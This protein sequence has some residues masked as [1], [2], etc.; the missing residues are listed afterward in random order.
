MERLQAEN[1]QEWAKREQLETEKLSL[2]R[3]NKK[4][5]KEIETL[6]EELNRKNQQHTAMMD[7]D[8]KKAK[9]ELEQKTKVSFFCVKYEMIVTMVSVS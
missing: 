7:C 9:L 5:K 1:A 8:L 6:E 2:E 3:E 4:M